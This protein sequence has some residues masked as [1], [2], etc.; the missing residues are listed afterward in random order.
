MI[1]LHMRLKIR[2]A[3]GQ[4]IRQTLKSLGR[5]IRARPGCSRYAF[6]VRARDNNGMVV[7][8]WDGRVAL[9]N[10]LRSDEHKVL[11]GAISTLC[12]GCTVRFRGN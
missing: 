12:S 9:N 10:Y 7:Q 6:Y 2:E 1:E 8:A 4:E 5:M 3:K 11:L